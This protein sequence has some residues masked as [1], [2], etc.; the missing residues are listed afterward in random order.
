MSSRTRRIGMRRRPRQ[1]P[2]NLSNMIRPRVIEGAMYAVEKAF[3]G[4]CENNIGVG[5]VLDKY[6][7]N[8]SGKSVQGLANPQ[9]RKCEKAVTYPTAAPGRCGLRSRRCTA[10][11]LSRGGAEIAEG[12]DFSASSAAPREPSPSSIVQNQT[13]WPAFAGHDTGIFDCDAA[14]GLAR[15][16]AE[17]AEGR[18]FSATSAAPREPSPSSIVQN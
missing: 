13:G 16:G 1:R 11:R 6:W 4:V 17:I 9:P 10:N 18:E 8:N 14:N 7:R 5:Q 2:R 3:Q 15:G 12:R